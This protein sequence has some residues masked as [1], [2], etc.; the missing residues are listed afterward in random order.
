M[1]SA[2]MVFFLGIAYA[3]ILI[4]GL[5]AQKNPQEPVADPYFTLLELLILVLAPLAVVIMVVVHAWAAREVKIYSLTAVI[6]MSLLAG[7]TC[8]VHFVIL[9]VSRQPDV[10]HLPWLPLFLS[11]K[12]PSVVYALDIL[13][14]DVFYGLAVL[15]AAPVFRGDQLAAAIRILLTVSGMLALAGLIGVPLGDM[16]LRLLVGGVG[17]AVLFPIVSLLLA[18]VFRHTEPVLA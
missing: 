18:L 9:T 10:A 6:F 15:F 14:W 17:Y 3:I 13:A 16:N 8:C 1:I 12:W 2:L 11:F 5:L 7:V 4:L